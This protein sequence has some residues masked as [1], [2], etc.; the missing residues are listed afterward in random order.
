MFGFGTCT[1]FIQGDPHRMRLQETTVQTLN[2][3][4]FFYLLFSAIVN[5]FLSLP[6]LYINYYL[7]GPALPREQKKFDF[8]SLNRPPVTH[9]WPQKNSAPSV[10]PFGRPFVTYIYECLVLLYRLKDCIQGRRLNLT[11][12]SWDLKSLRSSLQ[13]HSLFVTL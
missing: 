13:S 8:F 12:V 9:E 10:Q 5:L 2:S 11:L 7:K 6:Y 1:L 3:L 4:F